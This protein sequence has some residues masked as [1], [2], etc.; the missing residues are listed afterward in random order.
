[1][2]AF[3]ADLRLAA[4]ALGR[5]PAWTATIVLTLALGLGGAIA[6]GSLAYGVLLRP[7]PYP[8]ADRLIRLY[9][10][11]GRGS[12]MQVADPNFLDLQASGAFA[13]LAEVQSGAVAVQLAEQPA[14]IGLANVSRDF[15]PVFGVRPLAGREFTRAEL[16]VG[17]PRV[18][19]IGEA[20]WR[21]R[22]GASADLAALG[23]RVQGVPY[24]VVGVLPAAFDFPAGTGIWTPR[25]QD[26]F[27]PSRT[28]HNSRVFGR[29]AAGTTL[30][31][32]RARTSAVAARLVAEL[33]DR[34]DLRDVAV[35]PLRESLTA[36]ARPA[37]LAELAAAAALLLVAIVNAAGLLSARLE[38]RRRE[39]ATR[40][41]LGA[42]GRE[43]VR[44]LL[45]ESSLL[46]GAGSVLGLFGAAFGIRLLRGAAP[47]FLPR[48]DAVRIDLPVALLALAVT[49]AAAVTLAALT[50]RRVLGWNV[51]SELRA[52]AVATL[53]GRRRRLAGLPVAVQ[54]AA[55]FVL[56]VGVALLATSLT[57]LLAVRPGF[58]LAT[59]EALDVEPAEIRDDAAKVRRA[60]ALAELVARIEALPGGAR[61]GL[62]SGL[63]IAGSFSNGTFLE[64]ADPDRVPSD[65]AGFERL[66]RGGARTGFA[67]YVAASEGYFPAAG[68]PLR[69]GRLFDPRDTL[70]APHVAVVSESVARAVWPGESA[71][72][73]YLEFG[74]IDGDLRPLRVVGVV[75][76]VH[77]TGLADGPT[78]AVYTCF[79]Q[80]PQA[81]ALWTLVATPPAGRSGLAGF[82][83]AARAA[84]AEL[85]PEA[86]V[87]VYRAD[88]VLSDSLAERRLV[89]MLLALFTAAALALAGAAI[90]GSV[91]L[92]VAA[93]S[94]EM[95][96]RLALGA[97]TSRMTGQAM[98]RGLAPVAAGL[99]AGLA[100]ALV[101]GRL[102]RSLLFGVAPGSPVALAAAFTALAVLAVVAAWLPARRAARVSPSEALRAD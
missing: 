46:V 88:R 44:Q 43:I 83:D 68:I 50:A 99:A 47:A 75:G 72:G 55:A 37:L 27:L 64:L 58:E 70:A 53:G 93:R 16:A 85:F 15:F 78:P 79:R 62:T 100:I 17:A 18:A 23:L 59:T 4:R 11:D 25:E 35:V 95:A 80:R 3:L 86:P 12:R 28:A 13:G 33:G 73:R 102:V 90:S 51:E 101:A 65:F 40:R 26:E 61:A 87:S 34:I 1:M 60:A 7:L 94:R 91:A 41:A 96:L 98:A 71:L 5:R 84:A 31:S 92:A 66:A 54:S 81:A 2:S 82:G 49:A 63:P 48:L 10:V 24:Q 42:R 97:R 14:R 30:A 52:G 56:V 89:L 8:E 20:L 77:L 69:E 36:T 21:S 29:L 6:V 9:E 67:Y 32:A 38:T 74:N 19:L 22:F 57:R 45:A 76:D 39:L